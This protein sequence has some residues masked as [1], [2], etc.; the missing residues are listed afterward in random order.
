MKSNGC[1][2]RAAKASEQAGSESCHSLRDW[3][4]RSVDSKEAGRE[5]SAPKSFIVAMPTPF[6]ERKAA[7]GND[8]NRDGRPGIAGVSSS[9]HVSKGISHEPRRARHLRSQER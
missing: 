6:V 3:W 7:S 2:S 8:R 1:E 9:G 5:D 4:V